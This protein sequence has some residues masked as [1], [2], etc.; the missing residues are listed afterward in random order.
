[1]TYGKIWYDEDVHDLRSVETE[2][3]AIVFNDSLTSNETLY[4]ESTVSSLNDNE[5]DFRI[6]FDEPDDEDYMVV[7]DKNSFSYK[8]ISTNDLRTDSENDNEKNEFPA[9][10]YND[11][12]T[13]KSD[14]STKPTLCPQ[15]IDEFDFKDET[16]MSEYD[17]V[18]QTILNFNDLFSF[19]I[20]YPD[21]EAFEPTGTRTD[22]SH[23]S[24]LSDSTTPLSP[25][26]PITHVSPTPTPTRVS[27]HCRIAHMDV[28]TQPTLSP[29]MSARIGEADTLSPS[30]FCKRYRSSYDTS[31][32]SP[33]LS[34][35]KRYR[36]T[37]ELILNTD[38]QGDELGEEDTEE[39]ESSDTDDERD[40]QGLDDEGHGLGDEDHGLGDESQGLEGEGLG[41]EKEE[42][43]AP[44]DLEDDRVYTDVPA[45]AP[46]AA[47]VQTPPS[48]EWSSGSL[49][50]SPS[51]PVFPSPI[52]SPMA[53]PTATILVDKD[54]FIKVGAQL[55][56]HGSI[57]HDHTQC[58]DALQPTL[59]AAIDKD[60]R[61]MYTR[62]GVVRD[63]IFSQR[64]RF[65]SL[66]RE[67]ERTVVTF[68]ALWR[69][70]LALE[71]WAGHVDT[72]LADTSRDRYDNHRLIHDMLVQQAAMQRELQEM[73]GR[74]TVLEQERG[75]REP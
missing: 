54:Q 67:Q 52:A 29:G 55:E 57:L 62:S 59:V 34:G 31:S 13:S 46:P 10:V 38:S 21:F 9:I 74:V 23:S 45:Y 24:A 25:D 48:L 64:Y 22:S 49:P 32:S 51:S 1:M 61:E 11:A 16:S 71:A 69:P 44:E 12:L 19:N 42:E 65:R 47:P 43:V 40:S 58:L 7:F 66:E 70:V 73:R 39:D 18:E 33:T 50:I 26:Y 37:S 3:P 63:E 27:F 5:I 30:S 4:C 14:F 35:R 41:L 68:R 72:W 17:E 56:L 60:V 75:R 28:R 15:H 2:F 53:T 36:G 8:I 6:S 20:I